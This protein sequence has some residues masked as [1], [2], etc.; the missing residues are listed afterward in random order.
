M[1]VDKEILFPT[2]KETLSLVSLQ[3]L[4]NYVGSPVTTTLIWQMRNRLENIVIALYDFDVKV[5]INYHNLSL[6][7]AFELLIDENDPITIS[8]NHSW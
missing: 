5:H 1:A 6:T 4:S 7:F 8:I 2:F 3:M